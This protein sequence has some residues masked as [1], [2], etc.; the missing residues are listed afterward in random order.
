MKNT[1]TPKDASALDSAKFTINGQRIT[2]PND[3]TLPAIV[4]AL[5][6]KGRKVSTPA[7]IYSAIHATRLPAYIDKLR[8]DLVLSPFI[9]AENLPLTPQQKRRRHST[10]FKV[11]YLKPDAICQLGEKGQMWASRVIG[12]WRVSLND[13]P[14]N[15]EVAA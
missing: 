12:C 13:Y 3:D 7:L 14:L 5:M 9:V 1:D 6:L 2:L 11:Y 10:P 8:D 15:D 4:L